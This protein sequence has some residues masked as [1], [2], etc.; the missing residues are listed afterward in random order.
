MRRGNRFRTFPPLT[1]HECEVL[2]QLGWDLTSHFFSNKEIVSRNK[3]RSKL[4]SNMFSSNSYKMESC[5]ILCFF[6]LIGID[7]ILRFGNV[8]VSS[9]NFCCW[10]FDIERWNSCFQNIF[11][12]NRLPQQTVCPF[13]CL[14]VSFVSV[15]ICLINSIP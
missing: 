11:I 9:F 10:N 13:T 12:Y 8:T 2:L 15:Y 3:Q 6:F 7:R 14:V 5:T 4:I 1:L